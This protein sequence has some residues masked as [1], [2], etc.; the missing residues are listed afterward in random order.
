M[1]AVRN[2]SGRGGNRARPTRG[3]AVRRDGKPISTREAAA[4]LPGGATRSR[5]ATALALLEE[6]EISIEKLVAGGDGLGRHEGIPILVPRSAPGDRVRVRLV[7]RHPDYARAEIVELVSPGPGRRQP[8]CPHFGECGGCDL[9][10][11]E[12][13]EQVRL[14]AAATL[15]TLA[16]LGRV[17]A[18]ADFS[19]IS[20]EPWAYRLRAQV[21]TEAR[22][23]GVAVGYYARRSRDLVAVASCAV[24]APALETVVLSLPEQLTAV[25]PTRVDLL[26]GDGG[27]A[28]V[29]PVIE[30]LPHGEIT[31][32]VGEFAYALDARCFF[33]GHRGLLGRLVEE[34]VGEDRGER[35]V[36][37]FAGVGLF[38]LPL[39]RRYARV[40]AV[41]G[42]RIAARYARK[43]AVRHRLVN[44]TV[45]ARAVESWIA[46]LPAGTDRVVAD[47]PRT[48][49][50]GAVVATLLDRLPRRLTYVS[51]HPAALA[52]D[53]KALS[54]GYRLER[55]T[56]LDLF[57]QTGH[58]EAVAQLAAR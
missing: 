35:A 25:R 19:I 15:E 24:L 13:S 38:T 53:L 46:A 45:E 36:D 50:G 28:S 41:E 40:V 32:T 49:L 54:G 2:N 57:P 55:L 9:Q 52:R 14:K 51:C 30:G 7:E 34:V 37:L 10:H 20:G 29:A 5:T 42:D 22:A 17:A 4:R 26:V 58:M 23:T 1:G 43:N 39:A 33:Q 21:H 16:R 48:G 11:L 31:M 56:L 18:P 8:P 12:D 6:V 3:A 47:P 44:V 27:A